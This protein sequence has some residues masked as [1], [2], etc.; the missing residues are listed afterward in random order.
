MRTMS[1]LVQNLEVTQDVRPA[2]ERAAQR[3]QLPRLRAWIADAM[4]DEHRDLQFR[5]PSAVEV[6][7]R[8]RLVH[9]AEPGA[10]MC[11]QEL[12]TRLRRHALEK[13]ARGWLVLEV[14]RRL[15]DGARDPVGRGKPHQQ[16]NDGAV[17]VSP[18]D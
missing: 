10:R 9:D 4:D 8:Q 5:E 11:L 17:A 16:G 1:P 18:Q 12:R 2:F 15:D 3:L 7:A 14:M 13:R 6:L